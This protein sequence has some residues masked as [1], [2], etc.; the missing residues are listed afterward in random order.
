MKEEMYT[1]V[2]HTFE[3]VYN[4]ESRVLILG[5]FPSVKSRQQQFYYGHP[6]NRFWKVLARCLKTAIPETLPEKKKMLL[7]NHIAVWDVIASCDI[8]GSSDN[9]IKNVVVNDFSSVL[10]KTQI[11]RIYAN[12]SKAYELYRKYAESQTDMPIIKLPSTSPANAAW[13]LDRLVAEWGREIIKN[14]V[15]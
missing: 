11:D 15:N 7:E 9:S 12:G 8:V 5:S 10:Q 4:S 2:V 6:Q 14:T 3:P 13:S 1:H